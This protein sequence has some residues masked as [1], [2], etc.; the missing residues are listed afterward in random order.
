VKI[1]GSKG[2]GEVERRERP[3]EVEA[4]WFSWEI[5]EKEWETNVVLL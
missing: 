5:D 2:S 1:G 4:T 3:V